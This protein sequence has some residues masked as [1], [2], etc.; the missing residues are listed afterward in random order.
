MSGIGELESVIRTPAQDDALREATINAVTYRAATDW[1]AAHGQ[2]GAA[3]RIASM[4]PLTHHRG[5]RRAEILERLS[6]AGRAG[7]LDDAAAGHAWDA[8]LNLAFEQC[9]WQAGLQ[10][11]ANA[12]GHFE[13]ARLPLLAAWARCHHAICAWGA[14]QPAQADRLLGEVIAFFRR[15]HDEMGL[16]WSLWLASMRSADL[17][18]ATQMVVEAEDLLRRAGNP[19]GVA[20]AAEGRGIIAFESGELARAAASLTDAIELF[21]SYAN[22][23]CAAHALEAAAVVI[24]APGHGDAGLAIE[25][26]AAA[27]QLRR[28]SGTVGDRPWEIRARLGNL[29]DHIAVPGGTA[30]APAQAGRGY[31]LSEA[32]SLAV[33]AL[34]SLTTATAR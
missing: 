6:R 17:A 16:G 4:V 20:H 7:Q 22:I 13:A 29:E 12:A 15:E 2:Q 25:L 28:Q 10:A 11:G 3:L 24:G 8:V 23:G 34:R 14:G 33:G 1:A 9:E 5:E 26:L 30:S 18:A 32:A 19:M 27:D 21:A 31:S